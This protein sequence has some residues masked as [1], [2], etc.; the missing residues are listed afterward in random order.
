MQSDIGQIHET[1]AAERLHACSDAAFV[2]GP[3]GWR[4]MNVRN[5][6]SQVLGLHFD[7]FGVHDFRLV[8]GR[9]SSPAHSRRDPQLPQRRP[10]GQVPLRS[11]TAGT[12][13]DELPGIDLTLVF[14]TS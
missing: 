8:M 7:A 9:H 5:S 14:A 11:Y 4:V 10:P 1:G 6:A 2:R 12:G 13:T 3:A